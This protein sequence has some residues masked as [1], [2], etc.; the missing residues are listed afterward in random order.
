MKLHLT[1][2]VTFLATVASI[3][4]A[5]QVDKTALLVLPQ[6]VEIDSEISASVEFR[7]DED[8]PVVLNTW[9]IDDQLK[10]YGQLFFF[11]EEGK[12]VP[13]LHPVSV[14]LVPTGTKIL[15]NGDLLKIGLYAM[16]WPQF[17][18]AGSY[19]AIAIF[20]SAFVGDT[21]V[22]FTTIKRWFE[23]TG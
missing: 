3:S 13:T 20:S 17:P 19:Y 21:N 23:V 18:Q 15:Q 2:F 4:A 10:T 11:D 5:S 12:E 14:P 9:L 6:V 7:W 22:K 8:V 1:L 16:G